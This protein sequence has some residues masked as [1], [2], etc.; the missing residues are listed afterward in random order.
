MIDVIRET[1][2]SKINCLFD[3]VPNLIDE[4]NNNELLS[5]SAIQI[6]P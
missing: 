4:M 5:R 1:F 6:T 3:E 2:Q